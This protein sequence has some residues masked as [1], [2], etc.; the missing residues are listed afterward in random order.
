MADSKN[1]KQNAIDFVLRWGGIAFAVLMLAVAVAVIDELFDGKS[2]V[3][4]NWMLGITPIGAAIFWYL[5]NQVL[6]QQADASDRQ[7]A[8]SDRQAET[9]RLRLTDERFS[10]AVKLLSQNDENGNPAI[11]ARLGGIFVLEKLAESPGLKYFAQVVKTLAAY[12]KENIQLT[13]KPPL[14]ENKTPE[15]SRSLG[16]DVK[17]AFDVIDKLLGTY[18]QKTMEHFRLS[19][20]DFDFCGHDFSWLFL[21]LIRNINFCNC[22]LLGIDMR[23]VHL[24]LCDLRGADLSHAKLQKSVLRQAN[25]QGARLEYANLQGA[26]LSGAKLLYADFSR[27]ILGRDIK[28]SSEWS[29]KIW[30]SGQWEFKDQNI[31]SRSWNAEW[32]LS[33]FLDSADSLVGI[34][35]IYADSHVFLSGTEN[36]KLRAIK[37]RQAACKL[38]KDGKI[39]KGFPQNG[40][41]WLSKIKEDGS[42]P[43][44]T[45][46]A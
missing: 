8:A 22:M 28:L 9:D 20:R 14:V 29:E 11:A 3:F 23:G 44:D 1:N 24:S 36:Q 31:E 34:L 7:A 38:Q 2:E 12:I 41:D 18:K 21:S 33:P 26:D 40:R 19:N 32:D 43:D 17:I 30:H 25:L 6:K 27:A 5:R 37:L 10:D 35:Q 39:P 15:E 45:P 16:E 46:P 13:A 4:R 42:H